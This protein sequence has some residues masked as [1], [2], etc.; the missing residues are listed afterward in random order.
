MLWCLCGDKLVYPCLNAVDVFH[1]GC[2]SKPTE[3]I[4]KKRY[5]NFFCNR[6]VSVVGWIAVTLWQMLL[7]S[8]QSCRCPGC[9]IILVEVLTIVG[10]GLMDDWPKDLSSC[11][12]LASCLLKSFQWCSKYPNDI[13]AVIIQECLVGYACRTGWNMTNSPSSVWDKF[14]VGMSLSILL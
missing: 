10:L 14:V 1:G 13:Y 4:S 9:W 5:V 2:S 7:L 3:G 12:V 6:C 8:H 11:C